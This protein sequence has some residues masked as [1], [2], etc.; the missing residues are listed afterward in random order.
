MKIK[1]YLFNPPLPSL[2]CHR[3]SFCMIECFLFLFINRILIKGY[4]KIKIFIFKQKLKLK[5]TYLTHPFSL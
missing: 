1:N 3:M 4:I 2:G 5:T